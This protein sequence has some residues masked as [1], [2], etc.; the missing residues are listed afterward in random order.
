MLF[1]SFLGH[2]QEVFIDSVSYK[3]GY[4]TVRLLLPNDY[5]SQ[6]F[7]LLIMM[8][9]Q[10]LFDQKTSYAGEW[11]VDETISSFPIK[12][13]AIVIAIDHG[14][15]LR[16]DELTPY[17]N[18]KYGGGHADQFLTWMLQKVI[19]ALI[20]KHKLLINQDK[21]AI[22]GSS[23]GGLFAHYAAIK[24]PNYFQM[25][26]VFSPSFWW[27]E[28]I[29]KMTEATDIPK[30]QCFFFAAGSEE[31]TAMIPDMQKMY[32]LILKKEAQVTFLEKHG[33][34]HNEDQWRTTFIDFYS[35]WINEI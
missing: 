33:A 21:R 6:E 7:P 8:D 28:E 4:R 3:E 15:E 24:N 20:T 19:P 11:N 14:N 25:V 12:K 22:A 31:S 27:S 23:L 1:I 9:G 18:E 32:D 2:S 17:K 13:Q 35:N 29:F 10:N 26:G 5:K 30:N 34:Q 16:M